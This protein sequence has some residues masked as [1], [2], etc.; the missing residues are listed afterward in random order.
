MMRSLYSGVGGLKN[1]QTRIKIRPIFISEI[2]VAFKRIE[3]VGT[4][5]EIYHLAFLDSD[6]LGLL[7]CDH[8]GMYARLFPESSR[9]VVFICPKYYSI[10]RS[11]P[12]RTRGIGCHRRRLRRCFKN[13]RYQS[14]RSTRF[15]YV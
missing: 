1:H 9:M 15:R 14:I 4:A 6:D 13:F 11:Y 3:C 8:V 2:A 7:D 5:E 12:L 10:G